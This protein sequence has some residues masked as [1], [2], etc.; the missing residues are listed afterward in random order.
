LGGQVTGTSSKLAPEG[1]IP[2]GLV[3][4]LR[5]PRESASD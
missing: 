2:R 4:Y 5:N 1:Q 3:V